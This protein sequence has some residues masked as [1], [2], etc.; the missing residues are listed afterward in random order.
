VREKKIIVQSFLI[1]FNFSDKFSVIFCVAIVAL[2]SGQLLAED[3][4]FDATTVY[5][6][7]TSTSTK[8]PEDVE[9]EQTKE[10]YS[11]LNQTLLREFHMY[12][13][14]VECMI[15]R[16]QEKKAHKT[17]SQTNF[18]FLNTEDTADS[19]ESREVEIRS[20]LDEAIKDASFAC[21]IIGYCA[22]VLIVLVMTIVVA[23]VTCL[24]RKK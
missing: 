7:S 9:K 11:K 4:D 17:L 18:F 3:L 19:Y 14:R 12:T 23:C 15:G 20:E 2:I 6:T 1:F 5:T 21:T 16:M 10:F 22:I 8:S 13:K 24:S